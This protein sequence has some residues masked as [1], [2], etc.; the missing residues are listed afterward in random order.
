MTAIENKLPKISIRPPVEGDVAD[1]LALGFSCEINAMYGVPR[2]PAPAM[3]PE[4]AQ[5]WFD[6]LSKHPCGWIIAADGR[7]I[8]EARLDNVNQQ[9]KRARF[10][11]GLFKDEDLGKGMGRRATELI[12]KH[13]FEILNLH[14][15]DLR[16]LAF[17]TRA[18]RSYLA[19][20]FIQEG[21]ERESALIGEQWYDD[22]M[23]SILDSEFFERRGN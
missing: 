12:L 23:M 22:I 19:C 1:R 18:I 14:R 16:V 15:I 2:D 20:G 9:D 7:L 11:I 4:Q 8:G 3:K 5:R 17:N 13:G 6:T 21:V 10:A